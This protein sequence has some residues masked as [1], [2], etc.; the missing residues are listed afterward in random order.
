VLTRSSSFLLNRHK[1]P[2]AI[3]RE[4]LQALGYL[5]RIQDGYDIGCVLEGRWEREEEARIEDAWREEQK[6]YRQLL[7]VAHLELSNDNQA[8]Y[9]DAGLQRALCAQTYGEFLTEITWIA[10]EVPAVFSDM[11]NRVE[12][13]DNR[14][15]IS[16]ILGAFHAY[17]H[18]QTCQVS[19]ASSP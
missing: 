15:E 12:E 17:G 4:L 18:S 19:A 2:L 1:Y 16:F 5:G 6:R 10:K 3:T 11:K 8:N 9:L 7:E 14:A 13:L